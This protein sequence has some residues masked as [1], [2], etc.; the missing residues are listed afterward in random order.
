MALISSLSSAISGMKVAQSQLEIIGNNI[1]NVDTKG[2]TRKTA[3]QSA[4]VAAGNTM[5]VTIGTTQRTVDES[6]L[7]NYLSSNAETSSLSSQHKY[8]SQMDTFMGTTEGGNSVA[9]NVGN[10]QSAFE[11]FSTN[12]TSAASRYE[13]LSNAQA[14][15]SKLNYLSTNIQS[16]RGDADMEINGAITSVNS[17]LNRIDEFNTEIVK[18]TVLGRDGVAN[19]Q[20]QRDEALRELSTY[21]NV[22][23]YTRDTGAVVVQTTTGVMLLDNEVHELSHSALAQVG[24]DNSYDSGNILGIYV[25]G[26]D[27]TSQITG[28]SVGGLIEIRDKTLPSLQSQLDELSKI[29]YDNINAVHNQGTA[30]P[31]MPSEMTGTSTFIADKN[32][33]YTQN[34]KIDSGDVRFIIFDEEGKQFDTASLVGDIGFKEGSLDTLMS[35]IQNWM[36]TKAGLTDAVVKMD[37]NNH[38]VID[39]GDSNYTISIVDETTSN[40]GSTPQDVTISFDVNGDGV[41]DTTE[42][43]FSNFFGLNNFFAVNQNEYIYDSKV[44]NSKTAVGVNAP[45]TWSFSDS[46]NG[47]DYGSVTITKSMTIQDIANEINTNEDLNTH[48]KASLIANGDGY[49][50]RI[51]SL[52]G[53]Q[54]EIAETAGGGVFE[55]LEMGVSNCG[56]SASINVRQDIIENANKIVCGSPDFDSASGTYVLNSASN[57]I[58]N[59][60]AAV[61]TNSHTF[62]QSGDMAKTTTTISTFTST[63]VGNV[64]SLTNTAKSSYEYQSSLTEAISYKEAQISGID[65]DEELSQMLIYQQSYA[66]CAQV[67]TVSREI[68][69]V[70]LGLV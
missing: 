6:L 19:L 57:N 60:L 58:A 63:F 43:G 22:T 27:I 7:K 62:K 25:D 33:N 40:A 45:T 20:D 30:Y 65:I 24:A 52:E 39:T 37:G 47:F 15:T 34:I 11:T 49:M 50:L 38:L 8:L 70:L 61:F 9:A 66:A 67:F 4:L 17:L 48:I 5:G 2:Y 28:G 26:K 41:Y 44:V 68:L 16:L 69:D 59:K 54:L 35:E 23:Y 29:L 18:Y 10:L 55:K 31:N 56:Y 46:I 51:E 36:Q 14:L 53:A 1:A 12:V 64:A 21:M 13:L 42:Q 32:G 3:A